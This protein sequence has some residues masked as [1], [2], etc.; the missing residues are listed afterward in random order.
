MIF[1]SLMYGAPS[2]S[3]EVKFFNY[4]HLKSKKGRQTT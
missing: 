4:F 3:F 1:I 2:A